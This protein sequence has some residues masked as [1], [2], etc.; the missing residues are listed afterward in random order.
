MEDFNQALLA[1]Q[2]WRLMFVENYIPY[3]SEFGRPNISKTIFTRGGSWLST[4][5]CVEE[6]QGGNQVEVKGLG[7]YRHLARRMAPMYGKWFGCYSIYPRFFSILHAFMGI[8]D[9]Y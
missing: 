3:C 5:L 4:E 6:C 9:D 2:V 8:N 1:K 7:S